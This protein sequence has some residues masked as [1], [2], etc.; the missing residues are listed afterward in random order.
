M[1]KMEG[2]FLSDKVTT[3]SLSLQ[4]CD[5]IFE[6]SDVQGVFCSYIVFRNCLDMT[7]PFSQLV[8]GTFYLLEDGNDP[9]P[10]I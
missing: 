9:S 5:E 4:F 6:G 1:Y 10:L 8:D 2:H 7:V 3:F